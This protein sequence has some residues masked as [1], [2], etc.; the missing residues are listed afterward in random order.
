[1]NPVDV[2]ATQIE[3][4]WIHH[5]EGRLFCRSWTPAVATTRA[6]LASPIVL[7]HDSLGC[8]D[9]WREFPRRLAQASGR[10]VIAYDRLGFGRSDPRPR[11]PSLDFVAQEASRYFPQLRQQLGL[12]R[13]VAM[14]HSVGGGMAIHCAA[15]F[16]D[17]CDALITESAQVFAEDK[18]L[19]SIREARAQF[20]DPDQ[21]RRLARYHGAKAEW[22]LDAWTENWLDPGFAKWSLLDVLPRVVCPVLA[23]HGEQDEYG[24]LRHPTLIGER[25]AGRSRVAILPDTGHVPHREREED[26]LQLLREFLAAA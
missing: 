20:Q 24:S 14:G 18:T 8:V 21:V 22:V 13:F 1:M 9:L 15:L 25:V 4:H 5:P 19:A 23:L 11:R 2:A 3:D 26:V 16:A 17:G 7:F 10:R 6:P 12:A